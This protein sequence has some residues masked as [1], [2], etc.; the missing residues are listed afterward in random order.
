MLQLAQPIVKSAENVREIMEL[1]LLV[2]NRLRKIG[3][4]IAFQFFIFSCI[5][6]MSFKMNAFFVQMQKKN[7]LFLVLI[8]TSSFTE[9]LI[10]QFAERQNVVFANTYI[11]FKGLSTSE[12]LFSCKLNEKSINWMNVICYLLFSNLSC[13]LLYAWQSTDFGAREP[14]RHRIS[15]SVARGERARSIT[16]DLK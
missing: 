16:I 12:Y 2:F 14:Q 9:L 11:S 8:C 3:V 15:L 7:L 10:H 13:F 6:A 5:L 1:R 4:K